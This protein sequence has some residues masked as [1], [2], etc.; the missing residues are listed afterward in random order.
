[1]CNAEIFFLF[2]LRL[3]YFLPRVTKMWNIF[4]NF[5]QFCHCCSAAI[6][7]SLLLSFFL[8]SVLWYL[9]SHFIQFMIERDPKQSDGGNTTA[10]AKEMNFDDLVKWQKCVSIIIFSLF[11]LWI[12]YTIKIYLNLWFLKNSIWDQ[13]HTCH[14]SKC[15]FKIIFRSN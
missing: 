11:F 9:H 10:V 15:L 2:I 13:M 3:W 8:I 4:I 14:A 6:S 5:P 1:M 7:S 12:F